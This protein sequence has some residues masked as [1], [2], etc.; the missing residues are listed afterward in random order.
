[1]E[2]TEQRVFSFRDGLPTGPE[3]SEL[4]KRWPELKPGDRIEYAEVEAI[5]GVKWNSDRFK[6]VTVQWRKRMME[7]GRV[8]NCE[9]SRAFICAT[10]DQIT[11]GSYTVLRFVGHK[12]KD[13]R[14]K[15]STIRPEN[16]MQR[17]T[18]DH[19]ARLMLAM[20]REARKS[21]MNLLP[22]APKPEEQV[23]IGPPKEEKVAS[24]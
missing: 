14:R 5:I 6:T 19:H 24:K 16:E 7:R 22:P 2:K 11:A 23:R 12:A 17:A 1:M 13:Q 4:M 20:E 21:R 15:L 8:I 10:G 9:P 18:V 3:V